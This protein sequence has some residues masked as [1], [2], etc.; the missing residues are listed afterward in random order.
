MV[1]ARG[2]ARAGALA[3]VDAMEGVRARV[4][5]QEQWWTRWKEHRVLWCQ[6]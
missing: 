5:G 1:G 4:R 2:A 6:R 3:T